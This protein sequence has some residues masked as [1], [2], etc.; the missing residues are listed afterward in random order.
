M[1]IAEYEAKFIELAR[2]VFEY[3]NIDEKRVKRLQH[4]VRS[5]IRSKVIDYKQKNLEKGRRRHEK[6]TNN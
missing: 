4:E 2:F 3:V 1:S 5:W 6:K